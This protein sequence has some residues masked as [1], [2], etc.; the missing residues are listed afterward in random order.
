MKTPIPFKPGVMADIVAPYCDGGVFVE[1][2]WMV[3]RIGAM[4]G[5]SLLEYAQANVAVRYNPRHVRI[6]GPDIDGAPWTEAMVSAADAGWLDGSTYQW[7]PDRTPGENAAA[8]NA[9]GCPSKN[10]YGEWG[11]WG[12][13]MYYIKWAWEH[14]STRGPSPL[15]RGSG[16]GGGRR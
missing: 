8:Y 12:Y 3:D 14:P 1:D 5:A 10:Q 6:L 16:N 9:A 11:A 13:P 7:D 4:A 2:F 15:P